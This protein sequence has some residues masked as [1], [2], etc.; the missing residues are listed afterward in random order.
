MAQQDGFSQSLQRIALSY[1]GT[2]INFTI[3]PNQYQEVRPQRATQLKAQGDNIVEQYGP[4]FTQI[5]FSGTTGWHRDA[6]GKTGTDR[7]NDLQNM[8]QQYQNDTLNGLS[9][10]TDLMFYNYTDGRSYAVTLPASGFQ[11][12]RNA[13]TPILF[14]YAISFIAL[15]GSGEPTRSSIINKLV[16][17]GTGQS[18]KNGS[19]SGTN[20]VNKSNDAQTSTP[21]VVKAINGMTHEIGS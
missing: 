15:R 3:N 9:P 17:D 13:D 1:K 20:M 4:D 6:Q 14:D 2:T 18:V 16:G 11:Y 12:S 7:F 19:T 10:G 21:Y 8:L 5:S